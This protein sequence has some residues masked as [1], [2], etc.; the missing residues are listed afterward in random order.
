[1]LGVLGRT[2]GNSPAWPQTVDEKPTENIAE[3]VSRS[4]IAAE[5]G[6]VAAA[7]TMRGA[8]AEFPVRTGN[9]PALRLLA[10][11]AGHSLKSR[12][13]RLAGDGIAVVR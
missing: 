8:L 5:S 3:T 1:V 13:L 11:A 7:A 10:G 12:I 4:T 9:D 2:G 6:A